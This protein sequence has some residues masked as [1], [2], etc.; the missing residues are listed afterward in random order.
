MEPLGESFPGGGQPPGSHW[1]FGIAGAQMW[2]DPANKFSV[3]LMLQ[4][5]PLT[6]PVLKEVRVAA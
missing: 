6:Y 3:V 5:Y 4:E 1:W 2:V